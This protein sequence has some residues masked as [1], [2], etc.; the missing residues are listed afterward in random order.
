MTGFSRDNGTTK[1]IVDEFG[2]G[3]IVSAQLPGAHASSVLI[4]ASLL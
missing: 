3:R 4:K 2:I 1:Y